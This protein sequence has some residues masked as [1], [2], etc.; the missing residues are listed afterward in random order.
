MS[1]TSSGNGSGK[2]DEREELSLADIIKAAALIALLT[3]L[4]KLASGG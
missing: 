3:A 2:P 4:A 1:D